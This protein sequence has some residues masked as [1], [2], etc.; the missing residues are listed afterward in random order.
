MERNRSQY[1]SSSLSPV[2]STSPKLRSP[3]RIERPRATPFCVRWIPAGRTTDAGHAGRH[4]PPQHQSA[5]LDRPWACEWASGPH[6]RQYIVGSGGK[7]VVT[8]RACDRG[9]RAWKGVCCVCVQIQRGLSASQAKW[10][11]RDTRPNVKCSGWLPCDH[12]P[13][14][15]YRVC[16]CAHESCTLTCSSPRVTSAKFM[17][18][19]PLSCCAT[20]LT[21]TDTQAQR[22]TSCVRS[23]SMDYMPA[24][25]STLLHEI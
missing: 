4:L 9:D 2:L 3:L 15:H 17:L 20:T 23:A 13:S 7:W 6:E 10:S 18:T 21:P 19:V 24:A 25:V 14:L 5:P 12:E 8:V 16:V 22:H 1:S 11:T